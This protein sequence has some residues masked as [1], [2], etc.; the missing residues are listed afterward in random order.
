MVEISCTLM[1]D[2][3]YW[4]FGLSGVFDFCRFAG[5]GRLCWRWNDLLI[6]NLAEYKEIAPMVN[7]TV[8]FT[9]SDL[10]IL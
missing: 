7:Y 9:I 1:L 4:S 10:K 5:D 8:Y 6:I 2:G 3:G